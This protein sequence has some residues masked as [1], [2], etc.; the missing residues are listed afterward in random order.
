MSKP[1]NGNPDEIA[2]RDIRLVTPGVGQMQFDGSS[3]LIVARQEGQ[4]GYADGCEIAWVRS[5][6][7]FRVE[8]FDSGK[9][10]GVKWVME[11]RVEEYTEA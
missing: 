2:I 6:R 3:K 8:W 5:R 1:T 11:A 7:A 4:P 9:P 10:A